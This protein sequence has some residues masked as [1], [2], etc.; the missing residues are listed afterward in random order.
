M[1]VD[2]VLSGAVNATLRGT[3]AASHCANVG[4]LA[5]VSTKLY[6][7]VVVAPLAGDPY[8]LRLLLPD[9]AA[10]PITL[11]EPDQWT[12]RVAMSIQRQTNGALWEAIKGRVTVDS[13]RESGSFDVE[14]TPGESG[15]GF[16]RA[17]GRWRCVVP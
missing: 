4:S 11:V 8:E 2:V 6:A 5:V 1:A 7:V 17:R 3:F 15:N 13:G 16:L 9:L 14:L 12:G 10:A